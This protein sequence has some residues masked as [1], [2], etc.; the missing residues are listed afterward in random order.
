MKKCSV[1]LNSRKQICLYYANSTPFVIEGKVI[2]PP[3][4]ESTTPIKKVAKYLGVEPTGNYNIEKVFKAKTYFNPIYCGKVAYKNNIKISEFLNLCNASLL[5]HPNFQTAKEIATFVLGGCKEES[6]NPSITLS[7]FIDIIINDQRGKAE[8]PTSMN[9]QVYITLK[10]SIK[11]WNKFNSQISKLHQS[12]FDELSTYLKNRK[13]KNGKKGA[14]WERMMQCYRAVINRAINQYNKV[15]GCNENNS[16]KFS[17]Q[18]PNTQFKQRTGKSLIELYNEKNVNGAMTKDQ[19]KLFESINPRVLDV[20]IENGKRSFK[21]CA[22]K[23]CLCYDILSFM[24]YTGG[25]RP[26][27]AIRMKYNNLDIER[28]QIIYLPIKK[29]RF[30]NDDNELKKHLTALPLNESAKSII[31]KYK[32][33]N[34]YIFPCDCNIKDT[35]DYAPINKCITYMNAVIKTIG[36]QIGLDFIPTTYTMRKTAITLNVDEI[37]ARAKV[38]AMEEAAKLAGTSLFQVKDTYYKQVNQ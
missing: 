5:T 13:G 29:N 32:P 26:I 36:K 33:V 1:K 25:T 14:N 17:K 18:N 10:N 6:L 24:L 19:V 16:I 12:D 27:D 37:S 35:G 11:D 34:G 31:D 23:V 21:L 15:T 7:E 8:N 2:E 22:D 28:N 9:F 4:V 30:A 38:I 20:K 3:Y